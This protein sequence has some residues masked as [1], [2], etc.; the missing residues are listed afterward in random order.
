MKKLLTT[1][2]ITVLFCSVLLASEIEGKWTATI[3]TDNGPFTFF[4]EY[5]VSGDTITGTLSSEMGSVQIK[6]GK[7][8]GNEFEYTFEID[9][10]KFTHKG[11]LESEKLIIQSSGDY[12]NSTIEMIRVKNE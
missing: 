9:Y 11:K 3:E 2:L 10:Y 8:N 4:A 5:V 7:I 12:G 1:L 6:N